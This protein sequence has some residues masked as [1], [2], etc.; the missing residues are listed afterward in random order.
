MLTP[1]D[2]ADVETTRLRLALYEAVVNLNPVPCQWQFD[3]L[4][5]IAVFAKLEARQ[6]ALAHA[7]PT[8]LDEAASPGHPG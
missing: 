6:R 5:L 3:R 2:G 4:T 7:H 1:N 8:C